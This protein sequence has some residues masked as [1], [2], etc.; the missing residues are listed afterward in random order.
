MADTIRPLRRL[1]FTLEHADPRDDGSR[2][3]GRPMLAHD[4]AWPGGDS[5][6]P[7]VGQLS[8]DQL[9]DASFGADTGLPRSGILALFG[10]DP[11][12]ELVARFAPDAAAAQLLPVPDGLQTRPAVG[13]AAGLQLFLPSKHDRAVEGLIGSGE[14]LFEQYDDFVWSL[15]DCVDEDTFMHRVGGYPRWLRSD[16][17]PPPG[18]DWQLLW[19]IDANVLQGTEWEASAI[20]V[21][22]HC[23]DL[24]RADFSNLLVA[25]QTLY[26]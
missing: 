1:G 12:K 16:G 5:P 25:A 6:L 17:S 26:D 13:L 20:Y 2:L 15:H 14:E 19:Q 11:D 7:F 22:I 4:S 24:R 21:F 18:P 23:D 3:G 10:A 8:F 9:A